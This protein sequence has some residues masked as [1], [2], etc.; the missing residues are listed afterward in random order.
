V[1]VW[2][3]TGAPQVVAGSTVSLHGCHTL[4]LALVQVILVIVSVQLEFGQSGAPG[5]GEAGGLVV[6][7]NEALPFFTEPAG[8]I[9]VPLAVKFGFWPGTLLE[10]PGFVQSR[11]AV[12]LASS[13]TTMSPFPSPAR[14]PAALSVRALLL[15]V[16]TGLPCLKWALAASASVV[17][18]LT[19]SSKVSIVKA[20]LRKVFL[21]F[22]FIVISPF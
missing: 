11:F 20:A 16:N 21:I 22:V 12:P 4:I 3:R 1:N 8:T 10:P 7:L 15:E 18:M 14:A 9:P 5:T 13:A 17:L 6:T 19:R 2:S